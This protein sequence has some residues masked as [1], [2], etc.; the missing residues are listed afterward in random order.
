MT[1]RIKQI[2]TRFYPQTRL[3]FFF[4]CNFV[5]DNGEAVFRDNLQSAKNWLTVDHISRKMNEKVK[6]HKF[7]L[8]EK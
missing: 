6:I 7:K 1:Y 8:F 2:G 5:E 4:W 3:F